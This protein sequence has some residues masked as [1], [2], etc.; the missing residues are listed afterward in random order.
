MNKV[1][2]RFRELISER[3]GVADPAR[4]PTLRKMGSDIGIAPSTVMAWL[5]DEV[6]RFDMESLVLICNFLDCSIGQLL[7]YNEKEP[8][9]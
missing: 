1:K 9:M 7:V 4:L 5:D 3:Y 6:T 8:V 2:N